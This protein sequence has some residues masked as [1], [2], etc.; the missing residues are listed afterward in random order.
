MRE[1]KTIILIVSILVC[2]MAGFIGSIF[3]VPAVSG[4]YQTLNK[5]A[6]NPPSWVFG[7][8]WTTLFF[9]MGISLFLIWTDKGADKDLK[10]KAIWL[11]IW[12]FVLNIWWSVIFFGMQLPFYAFIEILVLWLAILLTIIYFSRISILSG[13]LLIP[14][15]LWVSFASIL[16]FLLWKL[17]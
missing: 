14:Y 2:E 11:F 10:K 3:T 7:V 15:I 1:N 12:Q 9:L 8:V 16:N 4:W 6:I 17:N 13:V 5:P